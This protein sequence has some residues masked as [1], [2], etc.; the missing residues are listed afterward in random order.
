MRLVESGPG[1]I[2]V[3]GRTFT[4]PAPTPTDLMRIRDKMREYALRECTH[5]L[6]AVN[7][8][9]KELAPQV[10]A[11]AMRIAVQQASGGGAE[12]SD[13]AIRRQFQTVEGIRFQFWY[14]AN[15]GGT[16]ITE[17]EVAELID[18]EMRYDIDDAIYQATQLGELPGPKASESGVGG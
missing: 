14:L 2:T 18:E 6:L 7:A 12:P 9:A 5:P 10:L 13:D 16:R 11:E 4:I 15:R 8:I 3:K 17:K 1:S